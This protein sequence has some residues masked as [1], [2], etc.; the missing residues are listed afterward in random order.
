MLPEERRQQ[1]DNVVQQMIQNK[2][3]DESI[4]LVVDDFKSKYDQPSQALP[5]VQPIQERFGLEV[6]KGLG[7]GAISTAVGT[8][9]LGERVESGLL[10]A[11]LPKQL[12][13]RFGVAKP[14]E[15]TAAE[16]LVPE[17][18]RTPI[19]QAQRFGFGA[20]KVGEFF[21][22][23]GIA[24]KAGKAGFLGRALG[25][26]I[27]AGGISALQKGK[28][29]KEVANFGLVAGSL[30]IAG[31]II[32]PL[33]KVLKGSVSQKAAP[34]IVNKLIQTLPKE[35]KFGKDPGAA[36][37][38]EN[39][40]GNSL[41]D[42]LKKVSTRND[43]VYKELTTALKSKEASKKII[44]VK[45]LLGPIDV[46]LKDAAESG[47]EVLYNRLTKLKEGLTKEFKEVE[48]KLVATGEKKLRLSPFETTELKR[49]IG[50]QSKWTGQA[51]DSDIN[52]VR[53]SIYR[54]LDDAID[55]AVP[56]SQ[57]LN[58]RLSN[59]IGAENSLQRVSDFAKRRRFFGLPEELTAAAVGA[60]SLVAGTG[61]PGAI[62]GG[63][64]GGLVRKIG[65][66]AF[67]Q[68]R[69]AR[70]LSRLTPETQTRITKAI[71]ALRNIMFGSQSIP[72]EELNPPNL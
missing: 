71:P 58:R 20:E 33:T 4:Q 53:V 45:P 48:G 62:A 18:L 10:R 23:G 49:Q 64:L 68:S 56:E 24:T 54:N 57:E 50:R 31:K 70:A 2:E 30:P 28:I 25:E 13:P 37:L 41:E 1:L 51:F 16:E 15:K 22:P 43:E 36:I 6:A 35:F 55:K 72:Q 7:K 60:G 42:Y 46:A 14:L 67:V 26:A 69:L 17:Q 40:V 11:L 52:K 65:G 3:T 32:S 34:N 39:I 29:D 44:D 9:G 63:I 61:A 12:E 5:Q 47:E 8:A 66:T 38:K 21:L 27:T 59:L 19:G